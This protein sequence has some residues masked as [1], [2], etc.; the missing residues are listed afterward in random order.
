MTGPSRLAA[1]LARFRD[2]RILTAG[3]TMLDRY[4]Y[5]EVE[6]I[7][8]EGPVPVF[9]V[10]R[11]AS[12]LGG[13]GNV[14]RNLAAM[15]ARPV[16]VSAVGDD[17]EGQTVL[18][19]LARETSVVSEVVVECER[20]TTLKSRFV[21]SGQQMFRADRE[22]V[23]PLQPRTEERL[24]AACSA[25]META[26]AMVLSDY[27]KGV[28]TP[29]FAGALIETAVRADRPV[30]VDPKGH[31]LSHFRGATVLTPNRRELADA[32]R[33]TV[34]TDEEIVEAARRAIETY[35][36]GSV[37]VTR[38]RDGMTLV[39]R[40]DAHHLRTDAREVFDVSG[41]GDTVTAVV[42]L[43]LGAALTALDAARLANVAAGIVVGKAGTATASIPEID[44]ALH[45]AGLLAGTNKVVPLERALDRVRAWRAEGL[46]V[47]FTNGCFDLLHPGHVSLLA[48]ARASVDR[49]IVGL[50]SD[51]STSR[52]KGEGRPIQPETARAIVLS[53]LSTVD[54]VVIFTEDTPQA[55]IEAIR[56][57]VLVKGADY[58]LEEVV[59]GDFVL[60]NGGEVLLAELSEGHSTTGTL[61]RI[62][63]RPAA[64]ERP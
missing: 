13:A 46:R 6:R 16:L 12:M 24:L 43:G 63:R 55:M 9:R 30:V 10:T 33:C 14:V 21:A 60:A 7:S 61:E 34:S 47:G 27:A 5:G 53:S 32:T 54:L 37:L 19:L 22:T 29:S 1:E 59:G 4:V 31:D 39:S 56:P 57:D 38:G 8:P 36:V 52:L 41:A 18:D 45:R 58:R 42:A 2:V 49:L 62:V 11:E 48:Q 64:Q 35:G 3:D 23:Q 15:E 51:A 26:S 44:A 25:A 40:D 17:P 28:L 20:Q 50:N